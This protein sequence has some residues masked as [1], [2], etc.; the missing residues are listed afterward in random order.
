MRWNLSASF[1]GVFPRLLNRL[2]KDLFPRGHRAIEKQYSVYTFKYLIEHLGCK[3]NNNEPW[4]FDKIY[5]T[6]K[7]YVKSLLELIVILQLC[8]NHLT[9]I[10][11]ERG[12]KEIFQE[13]E[14]NISHL[15]FIR[16]TAWY[17]AQK[18]LAASDQ[19]DL[20]LQQRSFWHFYVYMILI[21]SRDF[22]KNEH[23]KNNKNK[24]NE[25]WTTNYEKDKSLQ[26]LIFL[27]L[28]G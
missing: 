25:F 14:H 20:I 18:N 15:Y 7:I 3:V 8:Q 16:L 28:Y 22:L 9:S 10:Q 1:E 11:I 26:I 24:Q 12:V 2:P 6:V 21:C 23:K 27:W 17:I 5:R 13:C 19:G 4:Y